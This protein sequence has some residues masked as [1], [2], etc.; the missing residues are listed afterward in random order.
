VMVR[1]YTANTASGP[2]SG[3]FGGIF[4]SAR[5]LGTCGG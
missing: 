5:L 1:E 4:W 3:P 2:W